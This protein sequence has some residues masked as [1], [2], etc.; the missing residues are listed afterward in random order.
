MKKDMP[1]MSFFILCMPNG[2]AGLRSLDDRQGLFLR[3][4]RGGCLCRTS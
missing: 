1:G 4:L 2:E 3:I